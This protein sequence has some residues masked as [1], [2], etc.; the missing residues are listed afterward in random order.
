MN[1]EKLSKNLINMNMKR[2]N[3]FKKFW[4]IHFSSQRKELQLEK[5][6]LKKFKFK[7]LKDVN[8][9]RENALLLF[10]KSTNNFAQKKKIHLN[11][12]ELEYL[13]KNTDFNQQDWQGDNVLIYYLEYMINNKLFLFNEEQFNY[14]LKNSDLFITNKLGYSALKY[15]FIN[16]FLIFL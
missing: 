15:F 8:E 5:K 3:V 10:L 7:S 4:D 1:Q 13:I 2:H 6:I 11:D 16:K 9:L 14:I 12:R